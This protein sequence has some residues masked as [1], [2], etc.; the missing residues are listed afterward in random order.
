M[1]Q[2]ETGAERMVVVFVDKGMKVGELVDCKTRTA[3]EEA[4]AARLRDEG[5]HW[6]TECAHRRMLREAWQMPVEAGEV[7]MLERVLRAGP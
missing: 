1:L 2:Q 6:L 7:V 5:W 3:F 4:E